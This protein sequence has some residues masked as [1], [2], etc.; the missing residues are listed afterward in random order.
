MPPTW[1]CI[2][3]GLGGFGSGAVYHLA[4]RGLRVLGL[5]QHGPAHDYG[6]SHGESR[7]IRL[8]YFEH[9][10][11]VPLLRRAFDGWR[12]VEEQ[13]G[14]SLLQQC[15]LFLCGPA[16]GEAVPGAVRAAIEHRLPLERL[17]PGEAA[18]RFPGFSF[19]PEDEIVFEQQAGW[20]DVEGCVAAHLEL[21]Q[22]SGAEFRFHERVEAWSSDGR[23]VKVTTDRGTYEAA[24]L[25]IT[26]GPWAARLLRVEGV[27]LR[28]LR[29]VQLWIGITPGSYRETPCFLYERADGT[30]YGFPTRDGATVK[31]AEHSGGEA[32]DDPAL[33]D[34]ACR[35]DDRTGVESFVRH[36]LPDASGGVLRHSVCLYTMSPD[37]HFLIDRQ[38]QFPNV[39]F[40][41]G[42]SGHGFKFTGVLGEALAD[43]AVS[44]ET[45]L[46]VAFL[47][48]SRLRSSRSGG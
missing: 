42:F 8:A 47:S 15:G 34:R 44:G 21:A 35:P 36:C 9:P 22:R 16:E 1:D 40:G 6:S 4:Q 33:V 27:P 26:A 11:Y 46:P 23:N 5:E 28:V 39:V 31:V 14:R 12:R 3:L 13:S 32:V 7:I 45:T 43:L 2:V 17:S 10:D 29:K 48:L 38:P 18:A 25:I 30:F 19:A 41:A 24:C 37:G 20:L